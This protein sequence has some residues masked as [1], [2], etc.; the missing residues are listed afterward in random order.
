MRPSKEKARVLVIEDDEAQRSLLTGFLA[1]Q[2]FE[3]SSACSGAEALAQFKEQPWDVAL[4]DFRLPD[5]NGLEVLSRMRQLQPEIPVILITAFGTI[6]MAVKAMK[7]GASDFLSKPVDL[8]LLLVRLGQIRERSELMQ[9]NRELRERL[10]ERYRPSHI[11]SASPLM[12]E[13]LGIVS[14]VAPSSSTVLIRGESGT[15]KELIA[16]AIHHA[17]P[18]HD[19]PFI[20]VNCSAL[21]ETLLESEL[22]GHEKGAFTGALQR[23]IGRLEAAQGGTL[24]LDEVGDLPPQ[25]QTKLLRFLQEREFERLGSNAPIQVDVRVIA[26]THRELEAAVKEGGFRQDLYYRLQVIPIF[27]APLRERREDIPP[28]IDHFLRKYREREGKEIA[29]ISPE[30]RHFLLTYDY[31]GNVRELENM[32]E[33]AVVLCRREVIGLED[34]P[35]TL[36]EARTQGSAS[37]P[38]KPGLPHAVSNLEKDWK[39]I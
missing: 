20:K 36:R 34:L 39:K 22:F 14:R 23:R 13:V 4:L 38:E 3:A 27:L 11:I 24:F 9:E 31:P 17:S 37:P 10:S 18:R 21:P 7:T 8:D 1:R 29:G 12:E 35:L 28:L 25:I 19:R 5:M 16:A 30:A 26:A 6:E 15:G 33:R 32:V 2:G